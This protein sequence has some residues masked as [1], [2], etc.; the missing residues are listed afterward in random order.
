MK[1]KSSKSR[2]LL[3]LKNHKLQNVPSVFL[4]IKLSFPQSSS[5]LKWDDKIQNSLKWDGEFSK[6]KSIDDHN[7]GIKDTPLG[8]KI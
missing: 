8:R 1:Q 7:K 2:S 4:L 5:Y 3:R 6:I